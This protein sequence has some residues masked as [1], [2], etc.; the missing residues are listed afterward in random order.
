MPLTQ[1][2]DN[3]RQRQAPRFQR[4]HQME[5]QIGGFSEQRLVILGGGRQCRLDTFFAHLLGAFEYA[6]GE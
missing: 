2:F 3:V 4:H 5:D 6:F 1:H